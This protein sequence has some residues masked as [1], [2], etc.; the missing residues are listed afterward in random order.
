M[1]QEAQS[2]KQLEF[3]RCNEIAAHSSQ[4]L[5]VSHITAMHCWGV[6]VPDC[7]LNRDDIH[8][9]V[10]GQT[11]RS[12]I[13]GVQPHVWKADSAPYQMEG[14]NFLVASPIACWAQIAAYVS[15]ET[16]AAVGSSM[17]CRNPGL[18]VAHKQDFTQYVSLNRGFHGYARC[19]RVLP[20]L[21]EN[22]DSPPEA[23]L[24]L[25]LRRSGVSGLRVNHC[26]TRANG[27]KFY[28][29]LCIPEL[30]VA[31]EYQGSYHAGT[32]QMHADAQRFNELTRLGWT[33]LQVTASDL[34]T[35]NSQRKF[36][37]LVHSVVD[38]RTHVV[39]LLK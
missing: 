20:M 16:L 21:V 37:E 24:Y 29:D 23:E 27:H 38:R 26:V 28:L 6:D 11:R 10:A 36:V 18:K 9:C 3:Q 13:A 25:L 4:L 33:V 31:I 8:V 22:T 1:R 39:G 7:S 30:T 17:L 19:I 32:A 35:P 2:L 14:A 12:R 15:D 5:T 34:A